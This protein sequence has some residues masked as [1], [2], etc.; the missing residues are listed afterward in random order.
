MILTIRNLATNVS[1]ATRAE[2]EWLRAFLS[3]EDSSRQFA[4]TG[5]RVVHRA[6]TRVSLYAPEVNDCF[7][8]GLTALVAREGKK[9]SFPVEFHDR[10]VKPDGV[11]E[12]GSIADDV[13]WL[14][15]DQV[16]AV[17]RCLVRTRGILHLPT[18]AGKT[19]VAVALAKVVPC[20]WLFLVGEADLMHQAARRFEKRTGEEAGLIGDGK[21]S[22][23][24]FT[25]ATF[26]SLSAAVRPKKF[27]VPLKSTEKTREVETLLKRVQGIVVDE[28]HTLPANS[29][30]NVAMMAENAYFRIGLSGTPL[31]RGDRKS[32]YSI[33]ATGEVIYR[34]RAEEL[35]EK[36]HIVR[37]TI[38]MIPLSQVGLAAT[39][40]GAYTEL[41][42]RSNARNRV[43][44]WLA[45][46][47]EKPM[48]VFVRIKRHGTILES[49]LRKEG[50]NAEFV[51]GETS[52]TMRDDAI[53]RLRWGDLDAIVCSTVFQTG[54]DIPELLTLINAAGGRSNIRAIQFVGRV[55]RTSEGKKSAVVYDISDRDGRLPDGSGSA[56]R[57][58]AKHAQERV[59]A[60]M[61]EGYSVEVEDDTIAAL[62]PLLS[63]K[64]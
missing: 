41:V 40:D 35:A 2:Q 34:L 26:Q 48:L 49:M 51:W 53:R 11:P 18:G 20:E 5:G 32:L 10:R 28:V 43:V 60:Y 24:R 58:I 23:R 15:E 9:Q 62:A 7:P 45:K 64:R 25:V 61:K 12:P 4:R 54:T 46:N 55:M 22:I 6:P 59:K 47:A 56:A 29:F 52:T 1:A 33:A 50:L 42:V 13:E 16:E 3:F 30:F 37:P 39:Y 27:G 63:K 44:A 19:E 17:K 31:A 8:A 14:R 36:G 21:F 38:K 57:W